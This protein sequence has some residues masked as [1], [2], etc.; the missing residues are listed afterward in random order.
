MYQLTE[1]RI[2]FINRLYYLQFK[3]GKKW[4]FIPIIYHTGIPTTKDCY[5]SISLLSWPFH[6]VDIDIHGIE[7][8]RSTHDYDLRVWADENRYIEIYMENIR[9]NIK[10]H[11]HDK[12]VEK[13]R[14][15]R[16]PIYL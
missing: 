1:Y 4:K 9:L 15:A 2:I 16:T 3:F 7:C 12:K 5:N 10:K 14:A 13:A 8:I 11:L 6:W